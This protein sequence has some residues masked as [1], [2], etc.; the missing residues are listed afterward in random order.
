MRALPRSGGGLQWG[1]TLP[2]KETTWVRS[3][4][5][6]CGTRGF[7]GASLFRARKPLLEFAP[8]SEKPYRGRFNGASL[9]RARKHQM[10][11]R[12]HEFCKPSFNGASLFR[13]RKLAK[14]GHL[15]N[16]SPAPLQWGLTLPSKETWT[17]SMT[18]G[19]LS[20]FNG[21]SLFRRETFWRDCLGLA[22]SLQWGL[23]LPSKET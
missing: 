19:C 12:I 1:L 10:P 5:T 8:A 2:S 22:F 11:L 21:A 20:S 14:I 13:A 17:R 3:A 23:T 6:S 15:D 18:S 16:L 7:N 9:F 4:S